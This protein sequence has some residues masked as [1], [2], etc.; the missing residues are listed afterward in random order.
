MTHLYAYDTVTLNGRRQSRKDPQLFTGL[1]QNCP[2]KE[3]ITPVPSLLLHLLM[4]CSEACSH[5][6]KLVQ[7][8]IYFLKALVLVFL[9]TNSVS[10][11]IVLPSEV[12]CKQLAS[13]VAV[14]SWRQPGHPVQRFTLFRIFLG[15]QKKQ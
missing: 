5:G 11:H 4:L 14:Y 2:K 6:V 15:Y 12:L 8:N 13:D 1:L 7:V 3:K 10:S 9:V